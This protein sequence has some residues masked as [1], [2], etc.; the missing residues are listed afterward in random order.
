MEVKLIR[1]VILDLER[2]V[3]AMNVYGKPW[4]L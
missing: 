1:T 2:D 3:P 4:E